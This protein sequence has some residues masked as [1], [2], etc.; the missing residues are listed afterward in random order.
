MSRPVTGIDTT[1]GQAAHLHGLNLHRAACL[2]ALQRR[3]GDSVVLER[4]A[5]AHLDAALPVVSGSDWMAE[6]WL[7]A[8]AVLALRA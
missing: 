1:D 2:R 8:Y 3:L 4:A 7:A 5:Q 6:H